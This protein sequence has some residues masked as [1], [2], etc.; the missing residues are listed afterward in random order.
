MTLSTDIMLDRHR[1]K[2][3]LK[4]WRILCIVIVI[5]GIIGIIYQV[6]LSNKTDRIA[7][8]TVTGIILTDPRRN[9]ELQRIAKN[10]NV[11]ALIV[12]FDS[13]GGTFVG[14]EILFQQLREISK[15][16]SKD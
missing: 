13:P 9:K 6:N 10:D 16:S 5:V 15:T 2:K 12:A 4:F 3:K 14:G 11:K 7:R 1:L 8:L